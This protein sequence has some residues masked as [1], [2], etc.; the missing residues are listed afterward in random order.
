[1]CI[2]WIK[3]RGGKR[4]EDDSFDGMTAWVDGAVT[5]FFLCNLGRRNFDPPISLNQAAVTWRKHNLIAGLA[6]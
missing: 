1:M 3:K 5:S 6:I 4:L 2:V